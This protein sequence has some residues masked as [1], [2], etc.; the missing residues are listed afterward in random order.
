V[1]HILSPDL[2]RLAQPSLHLVVELLFLKDP[3][4]MLN[5]TRSIFFEVHDPRTL[6]LSKQRYRTKQV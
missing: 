4:L 1:H 6:D 3:K 2:V 5:E